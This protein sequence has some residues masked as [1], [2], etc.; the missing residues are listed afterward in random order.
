MAAAVALSMGVR[1]ERRSDV[2][3]FLVTFALGT[4]TIGTALAMAFST[5]ASRIV[6][7]LI[8]ADDGPFWM[9][10]ELAIGAIVLVWVAVLLLVDSVVYLV[11]GAY[12]F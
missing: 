6:Q 12:L 5:A 11:T 7:S 4:V 3:V 9:V 8:P 10:L 1:G 2:A